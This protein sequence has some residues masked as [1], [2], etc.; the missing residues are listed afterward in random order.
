MTSMPSKIPEPAVS[1]QTLIYSAA[2]VWGG[3]GLLLCLR[4]YFWFAASPM[5]TWW[6]VLLALALGLIKGRLIFSRLAARNLA[7]I[8]E[9]S[10][11]KE[12]VCF[13]A[14][15]AIRS[16]VLILGMITL[17][18]L[19]RMSPLPRELLAVIYLAIGIGLIYASTVYW[20]AG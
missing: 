13:F 16:W 20:G 7:R 17:G 15:Q 11:E 2:V 6:M 3:V 10:P 4:A 19:L 1:R 18:I 8:K 14:F 9:M 5:S 12:K